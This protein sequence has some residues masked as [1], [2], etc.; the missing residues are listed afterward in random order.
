M[1]RSESL[2]RQGDT[3]EQGDTAAYLSI[4]R[5]SDSPRNRYVTYPGYAEDSGAAWR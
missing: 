2:A 4:P 1:I 3:A 5:V